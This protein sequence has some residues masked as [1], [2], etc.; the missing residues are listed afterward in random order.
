MCFVYIND[1]CNDA[2]ICQHTINLSNI[3][4][5]L[6]QQRILFFHSEIK[7][8]FVNFE[9][10]YTLTLY[11]YSLLIKLWPNSWSIYSTCLWNQKVFFG[12]LSYP[13]AQQF[14]LW[15]WWIQSK[16]SQTITLRSI[17]IL[18]SHVRLSLSCGPYLS[19]NP[20]EFL[21]KFLIA[22][23]RTT[24]RVN[25]FTQEFRNDVQSNTFGKSQVLL[26]YLCLIKLYMA[27]YELFLCEGGFFPI[28]ITLF[29]RRD[30]R[31]YL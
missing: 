24:C 5:I 2:D 14:L 9:F 26:I 19:G 10:I 17:L 22:L 20:T 16:T 3:S 31:V 1:N 18:S 15:V 4:K 21:Y 27:N 12:F 7:T 6:R 8:Q 30:S 25:L 11:V 28:V 13:G 23:M 29:P